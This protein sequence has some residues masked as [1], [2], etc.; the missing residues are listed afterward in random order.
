MFWVLSVITF[1]AIKGTR[2]EEVEYTII[3]EYVNEAPAPPPSYPVDEKA[4]AKKD[5]QI[6]SA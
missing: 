6:T 3:H 5:D 4:E 1:R 2:R